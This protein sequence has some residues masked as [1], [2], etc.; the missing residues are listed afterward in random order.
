MEWNRIVNDYHQQGLKQYGA[1]LNDQGKIHLNLK[2]LSHFEITTIQGN[3]F[4]DSMAKIYATE[5][6]NTR[7]LFEYQEK[8]EF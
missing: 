5:V 1:I 6:E 4:A 8:D 3:D 2:F 7:K